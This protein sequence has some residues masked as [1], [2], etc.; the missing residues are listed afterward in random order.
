MIRSMEIDDYD[1]VHMLWLSIEGF[2]IRSMDD[3]REGIYRFLKRNPDLSIVDVENGKV[4]GA[5]LC[6][7]DGRSGTLYHVCVEK[8]YRH[9]GIG[10]AM[11]AECMERLKEEHINKVTIVAFTRNETGNAFWKS[12]GWEMRS[13]LFYYDIVLNER[14]I[15]KFNENEVASR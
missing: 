13:D 2:G 8:K 11:V 1:V 9:K 10:R 4:I 6:G 7:Q 15:T 14:N 12:L 5:I 3:S